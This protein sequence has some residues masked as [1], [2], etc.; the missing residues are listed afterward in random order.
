MHRK[1]SILLFFVLVGI[2]FIGLIQLLN[3]RFQRGDVY[4]VYSSL[5]TDPLG[6]K[7]LFESLRQ[8]SNN[9]VTRNYKPLTQL[10]IM[11]DTTLLYLGANEL[12]FIRSSE[13]FL[14]RFEEI[15]QKG[16]RVV[17]SF[18]PANWQRHYRTS[19][20]EL[21]DNASDESEDVNEEA[22]DNSGQDNGWMKKVK[23]MGKKIEKGAERI[24]EERERR[25]K[26]IENED[27][28]GEQG[29]QDEADEDLDEAE[30]N[31]EFPTIE[32]K[33]RWGVEID[34]YYHTWDEDDY[35]T[36]Q[37]KS[38]NAGEFP[39][40]IKWYSPLYFNLSD[41]SWRVLYAIKVE[42]SEYQDDEEFEEEGGEDAEE[43]FAPEKD[44]NAIIAS[45]MAS[46]FKPLHITASQIMHSDSEYGQTLATE[47]QILD[48]MEMDAQVNAS[49]ED[50]L[51]PVIV[52]RD[53]GNG[54]IVLLMDSFYF[55]NESLF[56]DRQTALLYHLIGT[57]NQIVFDESHFGIIKSQ[58]TVDLIIKYRLVYFVLGLILVAFL[59]IWKNSMPLVPP[60]DEGDHNETIVSDKDYV[61]G[62]TNLMRRNI[63]RR[64]I[65][66]TCYA[67]WE[68]SNDN[69]DQTQ[70]QKINNIIEAYQN[71]QIDSVK[72]YRF[73]VQILEER[74]KYG[75][76]N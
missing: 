56:R 13:K 46:V 22:L 18:T 61:E 72:A 43:E 2:F 25:R 41:D 34:Y 30:D 73:I 52:E 50:A 17:I 9:M 48:L 49:D 24:I 12:D 44:I 38:E 55:S 5:R 70:N 58:G 59:F 63:S 10:D 29:E 42:T 3:L 8:N 31:E 14:E 23:K 1:L 47:D 15:A 68:K 27:T 71:K 66:P 60:V 4:P 74:Y 6:S 76:K 75:Q 37:H 36:A 28:E 32:W 26:E 67:E 11:D 57:D 65:L 64:R 39:E 19:H 33:D 16:G 51:M 20:A 21:A 69:K 40:S 35:L 54:K 45:T 7:V 53:F 62:L